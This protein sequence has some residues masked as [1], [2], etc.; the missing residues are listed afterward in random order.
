MSQLLHDLKNTNNLENINEIQFSLFSH[1]DIKRGSVADILVPETY[2][3]NI[4]KNNGLFDHNM[5]SIDSSIICPTDENKSDLCPGYFGKVD[6]GLPVFN[7][8][9]VP[10]VEKL[11]KCF[12]FRCSNFLGDKTDPAL[13]KALHGKK[14]FSRF[15][16]CVEWCSKNK[17][18]S[19]NGGCFV[20]QPSKYV[21]LSGTANIKNNNNII[22]IYAEFSQNAL[23]DNKT[24]KSYNFTPLIC[25]Q[26]LKKI[27]DEDVDFVGLSSK[28]SRPEWMIITSLPVPP[29]SVRPSVRQSE[30]Q[31]SEDDLSYAL[32]NIVK[33]DK[34][35]K[36]VLDNN[37][38]DNKKIDNYQGYLQ[39]LVS[40]YM[41]NEIPGVSP[42]GQRSTFRPLK[43]ITQ[44]LKGKEGRIRVNIMGKRVDYSAR[45]VIS[46]D[47]NIDIDQYGVPLK[48]AMNLTFPE[49]VTRYNIQRMRTL[50][51][52]GPKK[53]PG[54]K[55]VTKTDGKVH[56][57]ISLKNVDVQQIAEYLQIGDIVHRHLIDDDVCLFNRQPTLHRMSMMAHR[58][59]ILPFSTFR[60]NINVC[61][62]YNADFDGD[63][64]NM[65]IARSE[66]TA[67]ELEQ[68]CLVPNH[69]IS[70]GTSTP[71]ISIVQDTLLGGYLMTIKN[72]E[73][74]RDQMMNYMMF[75]KQFNGVLPEMGNKNTWTGKQL[76]SLILPD[77]SISQ[78]KNVK[79]VR[80]QVT[81]GYLNS[82]SLGK[83][84]G[85]L[86]KQIF[87][88]YG[89][90]ECMNFINNT[91]KLITR[92]MIDNSFTI[93]FGDSCVNPMQRKQIIDIKNKYLDESFDLIRSAHYGLYAKNL[94]DMYKR[95]SLESDMTKIFSNLAE[96]VKDYLLENLPKSN[97]FYQAG[98]KQADAKGNANNIQQIIG[99]VGQQTIWGARI[100][101]GFTQ[102]TLPH[103]A[104]NDLGPDA[105]GFCRNSF[106]EG[107][108]PSE[109]FFAAM[110]GRTGTIDTA[111]NTADSGYVSR[112]MIK[113]AEDI[114]VNYDYVVR[115]AS[116]FI[117]QFG[118]G[119]D[120][121]DPI[122]LEKV[123]RIELIEYDNQRLEH[124]YK[125]DTDV[126]SMQH[127][128]TEEAIAEMS[129]GTAEAIGDGDVDAGM[130]GGMGSAMTLLENEMDEMY[131]L[132]D[133]LRNNYF[134]HVE[135]IGDINTYIP[136]N[137]F[138]VIPSQLIQFQIEPFGLSDLTPQY[139][140][141]AYNETMKEISKYLPEKDENWKLFKLIFKSFLATKRVI[142]EF[143]MTKVVYDSILLI[144]REKM[145]NALINPGEMVGI[146]AA[147]TMGEMTTQMTLNTF[148]LAGIGAGSLVITEGMPRIK[149]IIN[150]SKN[151]KSKNMRIYLKQEHSDNKNMA[152]R[153]QTELNF[154]ELRDLLSHSE[155]LY[156]NTYGLTNKNE[157]IEFI[158]SYKEFSTLFDIDVMDETD[159]S[160][161]ILR[162][163]F[164]KESLMNRKITIQEVQERIKESYHSDDAIDCVYSDDSA[165]DVVMRIRVKNDSKS[166]YLEFIKEFEKQLIQLPLRG[167]QNIQRVE[168]SQSNIIKYDADGSFQTTK[169]WTLTT[170]GSNLL[171]IL[172]HDMVDSTRT[173]TNDILE[174]YEIFGI[175]ATREMIYREL[176]K[177]YSA[178][179]ANPRHVQL[180]ADM[181]CYRGRLMQIDRHGMNKNSEIGPIAKASFEE[182]MNIFTKAAVFAE[183]DNMKGVSANILA[184]QFCKTGTNCFDILIDEDK[185]M[186]KVDIEEYVPPEDTTI[187]EPMIE[188]AF[189]KTFEKMNKKYQGNVTDDDFTFGFGIENK[190]EFELQKVAMSSVK[191]ELR[192][193][194][195]VA[196]INDSVLENPEKEMENIED[197]TLENPVEEEGS[198][199]IDTAILE[200]PVQE[201]SNV[202]KN[203]D[204][205]ILE[206]PSSTKK[207][208][209]GNKSN[210]K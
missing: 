72:H 57:N 82:E 181:M 38:A 41:D 94:D 121:L 87:N 116:G 144:I 205:A 55:T 184:G 158:K 134:Q 2:E 196:N 198:T 147:Q 168:V 21:R 52:N 173:V 171:E 67:V 187:T 40:T 69:I 99:C 102:R 81:E 22:Q 14:G 204:M 92:W 26:I 44:R 18:C 141:R 131:R 28:Y 97:C 191:V 25:Y 24:M 193:G 206:N 210:A 177:V 127:Y 90:K 9:F 76:F 101:D 120:N 11:L 70:P 80:G 32:L 13:L 51:R 33:A 175:E 170:N 139:V 164:D 50:I 179:N 95:S 113:A 35:L 126:A 19:F 160:P 63:E 197:A 185:L 98:D 161:W 73:I 5:G 132:R 106:I 71:C 60:L 100:I 112:K 140:I 68:I 47:P 105:K 58:I 192:N 143:R 122:R 123:T 148:H 146:I 84:S 149:E 75:M 36:Q 202:F 83:T 74:R 46:V 200:N 109:M 207:G 110:G 96:K 136:I 182:V 154:T 128:M 103:F 125:F 174:F 66:Q 188:N 130:S 209:R 124:V 16:T 30:N 93:G 78:L 157:D 27:K 56:I 194:N 114:I 165:N 77:I 190:K 39:Y 166:E 37:S 108:S 135:A 163:I 91:E 43:A 183:K 34:L 7:H 3:S 156:D 20:L 169:E 23:K 172:G 201:D 152:K 88:A 189:S 111:I 45:T 15:V 48:I 31:R 1:H 203:V 117:I 17:K 129:G 180:M 118:Y 89:M 6:L 65:H 159:M 133:D 208:K 61:S 49:I 150:V 8:H 42:N 151:M 54:A 62:P 142:K 104:R 199:V 162:L 29:P 119:D 138:R 86:I 59:K 153:I 178:K 155:I 4:P 195:S 10:Y 115:N 167:T 107:L 137:L 186:E 145:M 12:C 79:I 64:M 53:Y 85:G 176:F